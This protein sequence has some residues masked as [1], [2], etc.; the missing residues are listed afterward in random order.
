MSHNKEL[1][2][3][4]AKE[5][6][7]TGSDAQPRIEGYACTWNK[8]TDIGN[9]FEVL[10]PKPFTSLE[11]DEVVCLFNHQDS[12]ILGRS[13]VNLELSQDDIGLRFV[14]TLNDSSV[15][16]DCYSNLKSGILKECSFQFSV[17]EGGES[18][19]ALPNGKM[20]RTLTNLKLWD[21]SVVTT[22]AYSGTSAAARN[23]V[24][25]DIES[26]MKSFRDAG[27]S[28]GLGAVPFINFGV[29]K[30]S[31]DPFDAVDAANGIIS[32]ADGEG[33]ERSA[34]SPVKNRL[35]AAQGFAFVKGNGEKRSDYL[36]PHHLVRDGELVH[37][38][39]G[40]LRCMMDF[41]SGKVDV[42]AESRIAVQ[43]HLEQELGYWFDPA[44]NGQPD[45]SE[46][47]RSRARMRIA[48]AR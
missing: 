20:L 28:S 47:D 9:F 16:R 46:L 12:L 18:W 3:L 48:L 15:A 19:S 42:P 40:A 45:D 30:R 4:V 26:R 31:E 37:S 39:M 10:A 22:P 27:D 14:C 25:D 36:L 35:K 13:G 8:Q 34:D 11:T 24:A 6:R 23:I 43:H 33:D 41:K 38:Q 1:R 21:C 17:N 5:L 29:D 32:W 44:F 7:A 2:F